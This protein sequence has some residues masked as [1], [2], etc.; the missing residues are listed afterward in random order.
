M[1]KLTGNETVTARAGLPL[2][3]EVGRA[4]RLDEEVARRVH[5]GSRK[6][7]Y[8]VNDKLEA[9]VLLVAAGGDRVEDIQVLAEDRGL[10]GCSIARCRRRIRCCVFCMRWAAGATTQPRKNES[11]HTAH[12]AESCATSPRRATRC[13]ASKRSITQ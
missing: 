9:L 4:L 6:R 2:V 8:S 12:H 10:M 7:G 1:M 5:L 3:L 13:E 11:V